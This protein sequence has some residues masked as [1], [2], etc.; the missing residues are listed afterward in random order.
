MRLLQEPGI[1]GQDIGAAEIVVPGIEGQAAEEKAKANPREPQKERKNVFA[2][3][4]GNQ[5]FNARRQSSNT[6]LSR[7]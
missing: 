6:T 5:N 4:S 1:N 7:S 2:K 3:S